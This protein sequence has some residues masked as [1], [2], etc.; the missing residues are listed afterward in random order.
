MMV[1][2]P[3]PELSEASTLT[4]IQPGGGFC[5]GV[6]A[7]WGRMRRR[8]L[9]A[10]RPGYVARMAAKRQGHCEG[11]PHDI[12]D[13]RDLKLLRNVCGYSFRPEDDPF[14]WRGRLRLAR[15]GLA[16][17]VL[18]TLACFVVAIPISVVEVQTRHPA[19]WAPLLGIAWLWF[20]MV[21]FFRD[22][23]RVTPSD[24]DLLVSPADGV[25]TH[26]DEVDAPGFPGGRAFRIS[27]YLSPFN[28]H[29]NRAPRSARV[30]SVRYFRGRFLNARHQDCVA[31]N[32]Q[33][34]TDFVEPNGRMMRVKQISGAMAR[35][36]VCWAKLNEDV[37]MGER[38]G[39]IKYGSRT[40]VLLPTG[41]PIKLLVG[42]GDK[43]SAGETA[44]LTFPKSG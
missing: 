12:I 23:T 10:L 28:V 20:E 30:V 14:R 15:A 24:P 42:V 22:P 32:E 3:A 18:S 36:L 17:V 41:E 11:C 7:A 5:V 16:E 4:S 29:L 6:E 39:M 40:D 25:V 8:T 1:D 43:L 35:R 26:V 34:W 21:W 13:A 9:R 31:R 19:L 27:I 38:Y 37:Q 2:P 33:L 44:L